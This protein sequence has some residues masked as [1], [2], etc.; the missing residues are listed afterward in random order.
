MQ[1]AA[2]QIMNVSTPMRECQHSARDA[3]FAVCNMR[4][5]AET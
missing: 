2:L 5:A 4:I 3:V 1:V